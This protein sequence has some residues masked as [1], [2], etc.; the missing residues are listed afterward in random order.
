MARHGRLLYGARV[1]V[2]KERFMSVPSRKQGAPS[3]NLVA[4]LSNTTRRGQG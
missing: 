4:N 2:V 1:Y 3:Y